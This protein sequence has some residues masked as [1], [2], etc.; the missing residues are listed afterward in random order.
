MAIAAQTASSTKKPFYKDLFFQVMIAVVAGVFIGHYYPDFGEDLKPLG[1]A[2]IKLIKMM[3]GPIIFC[4][5]VTG[6][7]SI[8]CMRE[9]GRIGIKALIYFE[10]MTTLALVIGIVAAHMFEPG[11]GMAISA[12]S[13]R[14]SGAGTP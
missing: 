13:T 8:G 3:I 14:S 12:A 1:D 4:T 9:A 2:F 6:I 5:I 10:V 11:A 7:A